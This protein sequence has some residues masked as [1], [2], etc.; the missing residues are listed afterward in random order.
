MLTQ[1]PSRRENEQTHWRNIGDSEL[2]AS[3][4]LCKAGLTRLII[5]GV[6][7]GQHGPQGFQSSLPALEHCTGRLSGGTGSALLS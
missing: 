6:D 2:Q 7:L 5:A 1:V 3:F 4:L